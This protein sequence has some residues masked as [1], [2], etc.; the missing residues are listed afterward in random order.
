MMDKPKDIPETVAAPAKQFMKFFTTSFAAVE[1]PTFKEVKSIDW[2]NAG[3]KN[4]W[5]D[6]LIDLF[7]K[8]NKHGS[9]LNSKIKYIG[10]KGFKDQGQDIANTD[11]E[12]F[13]SVLNKLS[14]DYE[15]LNGFAIEII[16]NSSFDNIAEVRHVPF[17]KVRTNKDETEY[18]YADKWLNDNGSTMAVSQIKAEDNNWTVY[19]PFDPATAKK[20]KGKQLYYY[21]EYRPGIDYYPLPGYI[22]GLQYIVAEMKVSRYHVNNLD[23]NFWNNIIIHFRDGEPT[24]DEKRSLVSKFRSQQTSTEEGGKV[25]FTFTDPGVEPPIIDQLQANDSADVFEYLSRLIQEEI[26]VGHEVSSPILFGVKTEGQLGGR[27]EIIEA[28]ELFQNRYVEPRQYQL[29]S[30][31][32]A[33]FNEEFDIL[34]LNPIGYGDILANEKLLTYL[35]KEEVRR[36]IAERYDIKLAEPVIVPAVEPPLSETVIPPTND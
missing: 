10:G 32:K 36:L 4:D 12:T 17:N 21:K 18:Y 23:N 24:E 19:E 15:I 29:E 6:Y 14:G 22:A 8:S 20:N 27:N 11:E 30:A 26:F 9:I 33:I 1:L 16:Y 3:K 7:N 28:N 35:D 25:G 13:N 5:F 34:P 2:V 31:F